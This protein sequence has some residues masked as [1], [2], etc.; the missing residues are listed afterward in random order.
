MFI[1]PAI[2]N[3]VAHKT[4]RFTAVG[5]YSFARQFHAVPV[6]P[7]EFYLAVKEYPIVFARNP[8][9]G[10]FYPVLLTGLRE[11]QNLMLGA[12]GQ[13][14]ARYVPAAIR[15]YPFTYRKQGSGN[16]LV[17]ID[18]AYPGFGTVEGIALF[19]SEGEFSSELNEKLRFLQDHLQQ[20]SL[21]QQFTKRLQELDLLVERSAQFVKN[22][23][24]GFMV[25]G[26]WVIDETR[27]YSLKD[28]DLLAFTR[29]GYLALATAHL[30]S[31][32]NFSLLAE[33]LA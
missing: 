19:T 9:Q 30:I 31:L 3:K 15:S 23:H 4:L 25:N 8:E 20:V 21:G 1:K 29:Q 17:L 18:E 11:E 16:P 2:L 10:D 22:D 14:Q 26:C 27:L 12:D 32:S 6:C 28:E 24:S 33:K 13:W 5:G 7:A